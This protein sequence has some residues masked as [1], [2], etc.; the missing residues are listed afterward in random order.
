[1][2]HRQILGGEQYLPFARSCI[3]RLLATGMA[4]GAQKFNMGDAVVR[5]RVEPGHEYI[6]IEGGGGGVLA[7]DSGVIDLINLGVNS[8]F[9]FSAGVL[10]PTTALSAYYT[11]FT[12]PVNGG[13]VN[14][15]KTA[16]GQFL[17]ALSVSK[18][19]PKGKL[20]NKP[21]SFYPRLKETAIGSEVWK[22]ADDDEAVWSKK[23]VANA[24]P[25]SMFT[26][27]CRL[28]VQ[29]M[30]GKP[31]YKRG[32]FDSNGDEVGPTP[33]DPDIPT[34]VETTIPSISVPSFDKS[35]SVSVWT[36]SG[37]RLDPATGRH[38]LMNPSGNSISIYH[39]STTS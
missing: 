3:K 37:V 21:Y 17:G 13:K 4:Y 19:L 24:C 28:Y 18:P 35:E 38:F 10:Y 8:P 20:Y 34:N 1:M 14:P 31:L 36:S 7:M 15:S 16:S 32:G 26:G 25:A 33:G 23:F 39:S 11:G 12:K 2:E 27:K 5:V 9:R 30:Y 22:E 29:A 6:W